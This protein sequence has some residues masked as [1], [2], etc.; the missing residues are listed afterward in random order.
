MPDSNRRNHDTGAFGGIILAK[1]SASIKIPD[2]L[3]FVQAATIAAGTF[4]V[5]CAPAPS[6]P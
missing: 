2:N 4:T 6:R 5:V 3:D 1:V